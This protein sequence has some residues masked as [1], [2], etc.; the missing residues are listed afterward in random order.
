MAKIDLLRKL[1]REEVI[2]ALRQELPK[3]LSE[4]KQD[5]TGIKNVIR[6][7]KKSDIPLTLNTHETYKR[8][9]DFKF[10]NSSPLNNILL[11]TAKSMNQY[12]D[13]NYNFTTDNVN[14]VSFFQP[15]EA[16]IGDVNGMLATARPSSNLETVQ[17]NEVP[18]YSQLMKKMIEKGVI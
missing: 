11:E 17:I 15:K 8:N 5:Y 9:P 1:I 6:E 10:A 7:M 12:E 3:I 13:D 16:V 2:K 18:D 4:A 14:P